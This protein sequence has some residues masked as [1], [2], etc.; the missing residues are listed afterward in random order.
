[1]F[2]KAFKAILLNSGNFNE[3]LNDFK[4]GLIGI[5]ED[6]VPILNYYATTI[7]NTLKERG[8]SLDDCELLQKRYCLSTI[9]DYTRIEIPDGYPK[10]YEKEPNILIGV[11]ICQPEFR[12]RL[13]QLYGSYLRPRIGEADFDKIYYY[14]MEYINNIIFRIDL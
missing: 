2:K 3:R 5:Y 10:L 9:L 7:I 14:R 11:V 13:D 6:S 1:M 4:E 12:D 8:F